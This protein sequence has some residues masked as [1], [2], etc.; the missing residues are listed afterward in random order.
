MKPVINHGFEF[1]EKTTK[2]ATRKTVKK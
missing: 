1:F 2:R